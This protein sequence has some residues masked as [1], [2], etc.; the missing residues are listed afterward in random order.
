MEADSPMLS[1]SFRQKLNMGSNR[2][3]PADLLYSI[4]FQLLVYKNNFV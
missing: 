2:K 3:G 1:F 4:V